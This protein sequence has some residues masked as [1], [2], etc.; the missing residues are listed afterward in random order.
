[1]LPDGGLNNRK[2]IVLLQAVGMEQILEYEHDL[3]AAFPQPEGK[4][5]QLRDVSVTLPKL[6]A[7]GDAL[8]DGDR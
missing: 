4:R 8:H 1:M 5:T 2:L 3:V 6:P 7:E